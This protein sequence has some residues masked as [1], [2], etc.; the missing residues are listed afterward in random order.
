MTPA[1]FRWGLFL[2]LLGTLLLLRNTEVLNDNYWGDFLVYFPVILIAVGIEKIFCRSKLKAIS[3]LTSVFLFAGA[4]YIAFAG[5]SGGIAG[6]F[7][8][9][10]VYAKQDE[11]AVDRL[12]A[13]LELDETDLT[14]RDSGDEL[15]YA[16]FNKYTR[17]PKIDYEVVGDEARVTFTSR[18]TSWL[19]GVIKIEGGNPQDWNLRFSRDIPLELEC[20]GNRSDLHL[21]L[22][23][24]RLKSLQLGADET[25]IYLKLGDLEPFVRID[26]V[27]EDSD[28][29]LRVPQNMGL[30]VT[31]E[32]Y[33]AYLVQI[34]LLESNGG[35]VNEG[36]DTLEKKI[37]I[38]LEERLASFSIDFF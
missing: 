36:F 2:V 24:T 37:E 21:N 16:R 14:I 8:A 32:E 6:N 34:G 31:G 28:L 22:S 1:R 17:K 30:K 9:R 23:T 35:F 25:T 38:D 3:Y 13:V 5:S 26:I 15:I 11:P 20:F 12:H 4:L 27:G 10:T 7:F 18:S 29:R 33:H 19:G